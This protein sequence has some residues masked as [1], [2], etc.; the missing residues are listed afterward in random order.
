MK[1][2]LFLFVLVCAHTLAI[3]YSED[4][5]LEDEENVDDLSPELK[6]E[7]ARGDCIHR[8]RS[9]KDNKGGC[10]KGLFWGAVDLRCECGMVN[11][12]NKHKVTIGRKEKCLC[13]FPI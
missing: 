5:N 8:N 2:S 1:L 4:T 12:Y 13:K 10:C 11:I 3:A 7:S 9:C 6:D